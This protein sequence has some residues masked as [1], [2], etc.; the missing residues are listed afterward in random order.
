ML[1]I[2][3]SN[4]II[5]FPA[6][7]VT[8]NRLPEGFDNNTSQFKAKDY[9]VGSTA[10][11]SCLPGFASINGGASLTVVSCNTTGVW[12]LKQTQNPKRLGISGVSTEQG[13]IL[14]CLGNCTF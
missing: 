8:C 7:V 11:L 9:H 10:N 13:D 14:I 12:T 4:F 1:K 6:T 2:Y 3:N 5:F